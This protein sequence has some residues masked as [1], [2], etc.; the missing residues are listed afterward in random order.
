MCCVTVVISQRQR[1]IVLEEATVIDS[2]NTGPITNCFIVIEGNK[3]SYIGKRYEVEIPEN[4]QKFNL[5]GKYVIP[6]LIDVESRFRTPEEL[7]TLLSWGV[8]SANCSF[9]SI[10]EGERFSQMTK[11]DSA[12]FPDIYVTAPMFGSP[13]NDVVLNVK[14]KTPED[15]RAQVRLLHSK[16]ISRFKILCNKKQTNEGLPVEQLDS[17]VILALIDEAKKLGISTAI[18]TSSIKEAQ[19]AIEAGVSI[20]VGGI[21]DEQLGS[22]LIDEMV[23]RNTYY[24]STLSRYEAFSDAKK[25]L[26]NIL[27]DSLFRSTLTQSELTTYAQ[28]EAV[29]LND[30]RFP[31]FTVSPERLALV[32]GNSGAI[33]KHYI[34]VPMG[35]DV[36][37]LPGISAHIELENLV[38]AGLT[39]MQAIVSATAISA[40]CLG[41]RKNLGFLYMNYQADMLVLEK[42]PLEDIR[43]TRTISMIIKKGK[44]FTPKELREPVQK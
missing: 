17:S 10:E 20:L 21:Q 1:P 32:Y 22:S 37:S 8:T 5:K 4:A 35:T 7:R 33:V 44:I 18:Q 38:K 40:E 15:A 16:K 36:P 42:N 30:N 13:G 19:M 27:S 28:P 25:F 23:Q 31:E 14:P 9:E 3:I 43:N 12:Q 2:W 26:N 34:P 24:V 6:G 41:Q 29:R 11:V 39:P